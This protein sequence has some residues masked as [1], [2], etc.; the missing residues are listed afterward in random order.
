M[1]INFLFKFIGRSLRIALVCCSVMFFAV[2]CSDDDPKTD[3]ETELE[4]DHTPE[5]EPEPA[6]IVEEGT[7]GALS[8]KL[9]EN[10]VLTISGN[11]E[12]PDY[13]WNTMPW[14]DFRELIKTV[15]VEP[16]IT[17]I[18]DRAFMGTQL[19]NVTMPNSVANIGMGAFYG[20]GSIKSIV[21]PQGVT[22]IGKEVFFNCSSLTS[23]TIPNSVLSIEEGTFTGCYRLT[24]IA[25]PNSVT[26]ISG[27]PFWSTNLTNIEIAANHPHY[28][29]ENGILLSKAKDVLI[30]M[31]DSKGECIIPDGVKSIGNYAFMRCSDLT[32]IIIPN[33]VTNIG[34]SAFTSC[35]GLTSI[36]IPDGVTN[37]GDHAF[38]HCS[39]LTSINIPVGVTNIESYV[40]YNCSGLPNITIPDGVT[41]I[42]SC[43]FYGCTGLISVTILATTPPILRG[44]NFTAD[45][46]IL[47]VPAGCVAAYKATNWN[48]VFTTITEIK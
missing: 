6:A 13:E 23:I 31:A 19:T 15:V 18:G 43:A 11:G 10:G 41:N 2:S 27:N 44:D 39:G 38:A 36:T 20:C 5:P 22:G 33:G 4:I 45:N 16:G 17:S 32:S 40:F 42:G 37:I 9:D 24:D 30:Y 29:F 7:T 8:W 28:A 35:S 3:P 26:S 1:K 25:I 46:D 12:M 14:Y 21:I 47:Y 34:N 48:D